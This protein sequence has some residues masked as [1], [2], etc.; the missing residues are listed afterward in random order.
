MNTDSFEGELNGCR[1]GINPQTR[2]PR[3]S[4]SRSGQADGT[5]KRLT[6]E[7]YYGSHR[8]HREHREKDISKCTW[9]A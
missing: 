6:S 7:E 9:I 8:V 5:D 3:L 2:P 4:G 1:Q